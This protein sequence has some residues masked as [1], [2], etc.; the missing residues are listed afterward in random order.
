[1]EVKT[2][3][4]CRR[5][6]HYLTG[7]ELCSDCKNMLEEKFQEVKE[8]IAEKEK[9]GI[10]IAQI[11]RECEVPVSQIKE[12]LQEDRLELAERICAERVCE[13]CGQSIYEGSFC[14]LCKRELLGQVGNALRKETRNIPAARSSDSGQRMR[15]IRH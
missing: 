13:K 7:I 14:S 6:F 3:K 12:W 11:S 5:L 15:F 4:K 10:S 8:Y 9:G 2:C 1:M